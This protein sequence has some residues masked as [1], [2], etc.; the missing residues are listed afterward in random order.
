MERLRELCY[1]HVSFFPQSQ[2]GEVDIEGDE[3]EAQEGEE[4]EDDDDEPVIV[5]GSD[6][7]RGVQKLLIWTQLFK[8]SLA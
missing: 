1:K 7:V 6:E 3:Q 4:E 2:S 5:L 8:A